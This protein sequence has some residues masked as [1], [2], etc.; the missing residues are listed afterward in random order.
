MAP[1]RHPDA[2]G[3]PR[4]CAREQ[5]TRAKNS[6]CPVD[7]SSPHAWRAVAETAPPP[8][9]AAQARR[10]LEFRESSPAYPG[11]SE[12]LR[13]RTRQAMQIDDFFGD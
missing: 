3:A 9:S 6:L 2:C 12:R 4:A 10:R 11:A 5:G 13:S 8:I 7:E 1:A